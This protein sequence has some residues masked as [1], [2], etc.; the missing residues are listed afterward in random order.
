MYASTEGL[1]QVLY[2]FEPIMP[3]LAEPCHESRVLQTERVELTRFQIASTCR[4]SYFESLFEIDHLAE[5]PILTRFQPS[6]PGTILRLHAQ[7]AFVLAQ[8][9]VSQPL[10]GWYNSDARMEPVVHLWSTTQPTEWNQ[11]LRAT[12]DTKVNGFGVYTVSAS[13]D[14]TYYRARYLQSMHF[15]NGAI[16]TNIGYLWSSSI[17]PIVFELYEM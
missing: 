3:L 7:T 13:V 15:S 1:Q 4:P 8:P 12:S 5:V 14:V 6:D 17:G 9:K 2:Q 10:Y 11:L 16:V